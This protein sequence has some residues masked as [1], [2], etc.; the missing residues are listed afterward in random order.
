MII[1]LAPIPPPVTGASA[2]SQLAVDYMHKIAE[3]RT[4][5]LQRPEVAFAGNATWDQIARV[6]QIVARL[7]AIRVKRARGNE[8]SA[9]L[10]I[11]PSRLG[12]LRD[13]ALLLALGRKLRSRTTIH[14]HGSNFKS[15]MQSAPWLIRCLNRKLLRDIH[16]AIV[17]GPSVQDN[18]DGYVPRERVRVVANGYDPSL[19]ASEADIERKYGV[20]PVEIL[21]LSNL[22]PGKGFEKLI[23]AY[24]SLPRAIRS[25]ARLHLAGLPATAAIAT[26]VNEVCAS[27]SDVI[28]HG[29]V[30]GDRKRELLHR[31]QV[32]CLPSEI[33]FEG[34]PISILEAYASGC[35]V[36]TSRNGGIVDI[37]EDGANGF[38]VSAPQ[39]LNV[40]VDLLAEKLRTLVVDIGRHR[41]IG[42]RNHAIARQ[43]FRADAYCERVAQIVR[44]WAEPE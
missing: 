36:L 1:C 16:A 37:F 23:D 14:L 4:Y 21:F 40:S 43:H 18:F 8:V 3:V 42:L 11:A 19:E 35:T 15:C 28:F 44:G 2:A 25:S 33:R 13:L 32:F 29:V 5:S 12:N 9:Y 20:Q 27:H 41:T 31:C 34:Q 39:S 24:L 22:M 6:L 7:L 26:Y 30:N 10:V 38:Y 17:L